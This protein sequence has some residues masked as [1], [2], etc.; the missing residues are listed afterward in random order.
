MIG[1]YKAFTEAMMKG[2][3]RLQA[4]S[5]HYYAM[6]RQWPVQGPRHRLWRR[7]LGSKNWR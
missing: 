7:P 1:D 5:F 4:L 2:G 6:P 3:G